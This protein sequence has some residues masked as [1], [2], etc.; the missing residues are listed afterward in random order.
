MAQL[1]NVNSVFLPRGVPYAFTNL[2]GHACSGISTQV[3][4]PPYIP[5]G[6]EIYFQNQID[7]KLKPKIDSLPLWL[8]EDCHFSLRKFLCSGTYSLPYQS[9]LEA[10]L[11]F[12]GLSPQGIQNLNLTN[13]QLTDPIYLPTLL[14]QKQCQSFVSSCFVFLNIANL[15]SLLPD[16]TTYSNTFSPVGGIQLGANDTLFYLISPVNTMNDPSINDMGFKPSCPGPGI[17]VPD[18]RNDAVYI[19]GSACSLGCI[20]PY[21]TPD[22]FDFYRTMMLTENIV[23]LASLLLFL[24]TWLSDKTKRTQVLIITFASLNIA[25]SVVNVVVYSYKP[26]DVFC[27]DNNHGRTGPS[28]CLVQ[29]YVTLFCILS[30][31][32]TWMMIAIEIFMKVVLSLQKTDRY[33][34]IFFCGIFILPLIPIGI[35]A[36]TDNA[37]FLSSVPF[38]WL[39]TVP[40][41]PPITNDVVLVMYPLIAITAI[42]TGAMLAVIFSICRNAKSSVATLRIPILFVSIMLIF[43][44]TIIGVRFYAVTLDLTGFLKKY[45]LCAMANYDGT[46]SFHDKCGA[47][48]EFINE[49]LWRYFVFC[50]SAGGILS[51]LIFM[52]GHYLRVLGQGIQVI[53]RVA[54]IS[55]H[56]KSPSVSKAGN[57]K[58]LSNK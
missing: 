18:N 4:I 38:C 20:F 49:S 56:Y 39:K 34:P 58:G 25:L 11:T 9:N 42:G 27:N 2:S 23:S 1:L 47:K 52:S 13:K 53:S 19:P 32:L 28:L 29:S 45:V 7:I 8:T 41:S 50:F 22:D 15:T 5:V 10:Q 44:V 14:S 3:Y 37:G 55:E 48:A 36:G 33:L 6:A 30:I 21:N 12:G 40:S 24:Y 17:V 35:V 54:P 31:P 51:S 16:C 26:E 43:L 57:S 46:N